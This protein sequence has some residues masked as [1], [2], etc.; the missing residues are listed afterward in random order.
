MTTTDQRP[1]W[2]SAVVAGLLYLLVV[3][4]VA[5]L[6]Y[7]SETAKLSRG[8]YTDTFPP[9]LGTELVTWP[10]SSI[11]A[12]DLPTY[13]NEFRAT[14]YLAVLRERTFGFLPAGVAQAVLLSLAVAATTELSRRR[15]AAQRAPARPSAGSY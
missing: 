11:V 10:L 15:S 4:G 7:N 2:R 14:E 12:D 1:W 8:V 9:A 3:L 5:G 6:E 13:P